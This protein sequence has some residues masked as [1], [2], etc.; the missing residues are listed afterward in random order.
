MIPIKLTKE[1]RAEIVKD[2]QAFFEEERSETIGDL[3][4]EHILDFMMKA[5]GPY[6]YNKALSDARGLI[7]ERVNQI[8]DDLYALEKPTRHKR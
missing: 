2:V 7:N 5:I 3:A 4:A 1:E 6:V 8:E